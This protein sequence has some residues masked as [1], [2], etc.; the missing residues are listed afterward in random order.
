M[1]SKRKGSIVAARELVAVSGEVIPIPDP[2]RIVHLQ[3]RRFAGC[4]IC[5]LHLQ[6]IV[7]RHDEVLAHA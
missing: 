7:R 2:N 6:S 4:P 3:F 1:P 5:K